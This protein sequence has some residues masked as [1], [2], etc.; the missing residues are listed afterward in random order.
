MDWKVMTPPDYTFETTDAEELRTHPEYLRNLATLTKQGHELASSDLINWRQVEFNRSTYV[1]SNR[2]SPFATIWDYVEPPV[3]TWRWERGVGDLDVGLGR[4]QIVDINLIVP[5]GSGRAQ[6]DA[7]ER[8]KIDSYRPIYKTGA[9]TSSGDPSPINSDYTDSIKVYVDSQG[10]YIVLDGCKR[11][12]A[13]KAEGLTTISAWVFQTK[14]EHLVNRT[15]VMKA[16]I[17]EEKEL[18]QDEYTLANLG[19]SSPLY[20]PTLSYQE[21]RK[22]SYPA[23]GDQL[24]A[25]IKYVKSGDRSQLDEILSEVSEVKLRYPKE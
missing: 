2:K 25:I 14:D 11:L 23:I 24:D 3:G 4:F 6:W 17:E 20:A 16:A 13:A 21:C 7:R 9:S 12:L 18:P 10:R 1:R 5:F 15:S 8:A 22:L 19:P